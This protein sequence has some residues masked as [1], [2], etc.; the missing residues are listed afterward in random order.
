MVACSS[1][2]RPGTPAAA[3][4]PGPET[5][6]SPR[7]SVRLWTSTAKPTFV[8]P[9]TFHRSWSDARSV[10][11]KSSSPVSMTRRSPSILPF[12]VRNAA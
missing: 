9:M 8:R 2:G 10:R 5:E 1:S 4:A 12:G 7:S 3:R 11:S 6:K